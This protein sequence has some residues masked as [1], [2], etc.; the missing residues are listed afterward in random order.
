MRS[1]GWWAS[2]QWGSCSYTIQNC[3]ATCGLQGHSTT[4]QSR[5]PPKP[6]LSCPRHGPVCTLGPTILSSSSLYSLGTVLSVSGL[7]DKECH[8]DCLGLVP[9]IQPLP[10]VFFSI[11]HASSQPIYSLDWVR[12]R[13]STR[14]ASVNKMPA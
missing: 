9:F 4:L 11:V 12:P 13:A 6:W 5:P 7:H 10:Q 2:V 14:H 1:P 8:S 3:S